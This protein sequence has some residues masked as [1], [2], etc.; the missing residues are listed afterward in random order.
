MA[1]FLK[2]MLF[3]GLVLLSLLTAIVLGQYLRDTRTAPDLGALPTHFISNSTC[4]NTKL[5]HAR[6]GNRL[7]QAKLLILGSSMALHNVLG[8]GLSARFQEP[9]YNLSSWGLRPAESYE[10]LKQ[11]ADSLT[12]DHLVIPFNHTEFGLDTK[13]IDYE[14]LPDYFFAENPLKQVRQYAAQFTL[15]GFIE[16]W[17]MRTKYLHR[18][19][20]NF[21]L[22]FD[23]TGAVIQRADRFVFAPNARRLAYRD[24]TGF[25]QF[26]AGIDSIRQLCHQ[27]HI[28][29][30]LV[31]LPWRSSVLTPERIGQ[32]RYVADCL[33]KRY[34]ENFVDLSGLA[35]ADRDF[36]DAG[37]MFKGG[38]SLV[39]RAL[40]D[41]MATH[42]TGAGIALTQPRQTLVA[43]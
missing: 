4:F 13:R 10:L 5:E 19:N 38:A 11:L 33:S 32:V 28:T 9:V 43:R 29:L 2:K 30:T 8:P 12:V 40:L 25:G 41:S 35:V 1:T 18:S 23:E 36:S 21:S 17:T 24:T 7:K 16:D 6:A 3:H 34:P 31:Y 39:T 27:R 37:H 22:N 20:V 26:T 42:G 14:Q 15:S